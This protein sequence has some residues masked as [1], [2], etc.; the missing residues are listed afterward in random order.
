V[1]NKNSGRRT[2]HARLAE[3]ARLRDQGLTLAEIGN[4]LGVTRQA[5]HDALLRLGYR[6]SATDPTPTRQ[7]RQRGGA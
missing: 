1:G 7:E 4:R 3:M 5:V 2:N 6:K